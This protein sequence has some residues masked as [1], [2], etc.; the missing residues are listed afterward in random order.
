[1]L[2]RNAR[3]A[4]VVA[5]QRAVLHHVPRSRAVEEAAAVDTSFARQ[6]PELAAPDVIEGAAFRAISVSEANTPAFAAFLDGAQRT[7]VIAHADGIPIVFGTVAAVVRVRRERRMITWGHRPPVVQRRLYIPMAHL[8]A[9]FEVDSLIQAARVSGVVDT[10]AASS[11]SLHPMALVDAATT[12]VQRDRERLE[13]ELAEEWCMRESLPILIDGSIEG[14]QRLAASRCAVGVIKSH[15]RLFADG[16]ALRTLMHLRNRER[17]SVFRVT[18]RGRHSVMSWYLRLRDPTGHDAMWGLVRVEA[19]EVSEPSE[20]ADE[21]SRWIMCEG[22]P[23]A[24]PDGRWDRMTY[25][26]RDCEEFLRA[27]S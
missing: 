9:G 23:L 24:L 19:A 3:S 15:R 8:Q 20:R 7:E 4:S 1:L 18:P 17:S 10:T 13:V 25:G 2:S 5:A 6:L 11:V 26:I 27:I 14:S 12:C 22:A 16:S 21:V